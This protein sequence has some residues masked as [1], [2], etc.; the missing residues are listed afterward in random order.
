MK[1]IILILLLITS[2]ENNILA[3]KTIK[4]TTF[5]QKQINILVQ[6]LDIESGALQIKYTHQ[7]LPPSK[8]FHSIKF[9]Q[10]IGAE[11]IPYILEAI[12]I[13]ER[14]KYFQHN[15]FYTLKSII[16]DVKQTKEHI[17]TFAQQ[18]TGAHKERLKKLTELPKRLYFDN[19]DDLIQQVKVDTNYVL[20]VNAIFRLGELFATPPDSTIDH[21]KIF[22][23]KSYIR[24]S[25]THPKAKEVA[26][27]LVEKLA[28]FKM[29][30]NG[31]RSIGGPWHK[32][33]PAATAYFN[34]YG[35]PVRNHPDNISTLDNP[36]T[37][38][39]VNSLATQDHSQKFTK[40]AYRLLGI[41]AS[42][43]NLPTSK[44]LLKFAEEHYTG[45]EKERLIQIVKSWS[46]TH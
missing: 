27:V 8:I 37:Y 21:G 12:S 23:I 29:H 26:K 16:G 10:Q 31:I 18:K 3:Q 36:F 40:H 24:N 5:T 17:L 4:N 6:E 44:W 41:P 25:H 28:Y 15:A 42:H 7:S 30:R 1:A 46:N 22:L 38:A 19:I 39:L 14:S 9:L 11:A 34:I 2:F 43:D 20:T 35:L 32:N 33:Y 13:K 45:K